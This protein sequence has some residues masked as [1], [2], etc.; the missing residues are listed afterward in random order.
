M[1]VR[2]SLLVLRVVRLYADELEK[3]LAEYEMTL[4]APRPLRFPEGGSS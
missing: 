2:D 4:S 3:W 1:D